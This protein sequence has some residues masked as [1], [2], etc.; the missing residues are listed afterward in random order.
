MRVN[1]LKMVNYRNYQKLELE[2][3]PELNIFIKLVR[4]TRDFSREMNWRC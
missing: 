3:Q 1:S 2:F 4:N